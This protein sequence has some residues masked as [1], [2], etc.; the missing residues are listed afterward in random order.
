[1]FLRRRVELI[2]AYAEFEAAFMLSAKRRRLPPE[3][4]DATRA[5][6]REL[7]ENRDQREANIRV[8]KRESSS[9]MLPS[10]SNKR[11]RGYRTAHK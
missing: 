2:E 3:R 7:R 5:R 1:M 8:A 4:I 6:I 10:C 9:A 11:A